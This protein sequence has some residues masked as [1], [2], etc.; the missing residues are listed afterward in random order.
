MKR[1][2]EGKMES[3]KDLKTEKPNTKKFRQVKFVELS[4][5]DAKKYI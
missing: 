4:N 2:K 3:F 5:R 1:R